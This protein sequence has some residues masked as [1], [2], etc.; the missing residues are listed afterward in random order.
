MR[1]IRKTRIRLFKSRKIDE[2]TT[3]N[4]K[5]IKIIRGAGEMRKSGDYQV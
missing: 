3:G 1:S 2:R 5:E 4:Y